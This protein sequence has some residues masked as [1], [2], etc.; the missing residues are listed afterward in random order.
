MGGRGSQTESARAAALSLREAW[1]SLGAGKVSEGQFCSCARRAGLGSARHGPP[2]PQ[3]VGRVPVLGHAEKR[4]L[5]EVSVLDC[6]LP[7]PHGSGGANSGYVSRAILLSWAHWSPFWS[8]FS[9]HQAIDPLTAA[10]QL[11]GQRLGRRNT[12]WTRIRSEQVHPNMSP[13]WLH[14]GRNFLI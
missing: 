14:S 9:G 11:C 6:K 3:R 13:L 7:D 8:F 4:A 2:A 10:E 5:S 1:R 12:T